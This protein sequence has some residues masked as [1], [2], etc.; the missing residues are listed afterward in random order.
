MVGKD[1]KNVTTNNLPKLGK[2]Q[3]VNQKDSIIFFFLSKNLMVEKRKGIEL[4]G[5]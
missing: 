2:A 5:Q 4:N 1:S 3:R